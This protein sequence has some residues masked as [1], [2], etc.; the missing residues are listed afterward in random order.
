MSPSSVGITDPMPRHRQGRAACA[1][2]RRRN[3]A[4]YV[5]IGKPG[6]KSIADLKGSIWLARTNDITT[7]YFERMMAAKRA[8]EGGHTC[9]FRR[10]RSGAFCRR[11]GPRRRCRGRASAAQFPGHGGGFV[12][13][14]LAADYVKDNSVY[15]HGSPPALGGRESAGRQRILAATA[16]AS[17]GWRHPRTAT[18]RS[19]CGQGC[20]FEQRGCRGQLEL[21]PPH[22]IFEPN[23]KI[24]RAKLRNLVAME[25]RAGTVDPALAIDRL[26]MPGLT[27]LIRLIGGDKGPKSTA[28]APAGSAILFSYVHIQ[29][30]RP[31]VQVCPRSPGTASSCIAKRP[32]RDAGGLPST[33]RRGPPDLEPQMRHFSRSTAASPLASARLSA[34]RHPNDPTSISRTRSAT[35]SSR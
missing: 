5:L 12:T 3:A 35:M 4:P 30:C 31:R 18:K 20:P 34:V 6:L 15:R 9:T 1:H 13:L 25:Q 32:V 23:S 24:S 27:E 22:R 2:S 11:S 21:S 28:C 26:I 29:F 8:Q 14:G 7:V 16:R 19:S 17:P 33:N 10:R